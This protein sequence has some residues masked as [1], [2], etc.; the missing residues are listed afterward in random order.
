MKSDIRRAGINP[1]HWYAVA[2]SSEV[3]KQNILGVRLWGQPMAIFRDT[4]EQLQC[5][6]DRCPHRNVQL[7]HGRL[8]GSSLECAY[9]GWRVDSSGACVAIPYLEENQKLPTCR[10][11]SFPVREQQGLIWVFPGDPD[12]AGHVPCLEMPEWDDLNYVASVAEIDTQAHFSFLIENLIDMYHGHLHAQY[13]AWSNAHL[14]EIKQSDERLEV[15]YEAITHMRVQSIFSPAQLLLPQL[16]KAHPVDLTV[17]YLY[18][19]WSSSLGSDFRLYCM[20]CPISATHTKAYLIHFTSLHSFNYL[21]MVPTR[22]RKWMKSLFFNSA[23]ILLDRLIAQDVQMIEEEQRAFENQPTAGS[24]EFN[25][26]LIG[27]QRLILSQACAPSDCRT[28]TNQPK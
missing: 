12:L 3:S 21:N 26:A 11:R 14:I 9:H 4:S 16:R 28:T 27:V 20:L 13:Q 1:N 7:S 2:Q 6:E 10:I 24:V 19:H 5:L 15:C 8:V 23:K 18:P 25:R 17:R 22:V